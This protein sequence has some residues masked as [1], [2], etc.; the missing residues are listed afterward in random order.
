M[1]LYV[2]AE[3]VTQTGGLDLA[4][5]F[6]LGK[7]NSTFWAQVSVSDCFR[8]L[9]DRRRAVCMWGLFGGGGVVRLSRH[10]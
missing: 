10:V 5:N 1:M 8:Y 2:V 6:M 4:M 3:G 7:A 9:G